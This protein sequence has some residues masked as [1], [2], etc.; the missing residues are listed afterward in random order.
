MNRIILLAVVVLACLFGNCQKE[1]GKADPDNFGNGPRT[2]VPVSLQ[3][4]WM[5]GYFS[6]TEYW[7][8]NPAEYIGNGFQFAIAFKFNANGTYEQYFTSSTVSGTVVTYQQSVTK[9]TV[10][11]DESA[12]TIITH[13]NTAHYK[14]TKNGQT[15]QERDLK[16]SELTATTKYT[17]ES[18][19]ENNGS[20]AIY[21]KLN[22][23]G[24]ALTF[25][26][27]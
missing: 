23:T 8:Q 1:K 17:Y 24:N 20:K 25:L 13:A 5:Y 14:E 3:G 21:L 7:S 12:Q 22:G 18:G 4:S 6:M 19:T 10:E 26:Q 9:G 27:M 16:K 11:V 2:N 15:T